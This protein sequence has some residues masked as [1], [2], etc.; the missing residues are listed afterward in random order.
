[1]DAEP[2]AGEPGGWPGLVMFDLDGT[3]VDSAPDIRLAINRVL[4]EQ[5]HEA[6]TPGDVQ[7]MIGNGIGK[8][9]ERAFAARGDIL[10]GDALA[11][12]TERMMATYR[13]NLTVETVPMP[14]ALDAVS[15]LRANGARIAVVTNK[16]ESFSREI[17]SALGF[18][19]LIDGVVG[20]DT[21]A[22][23]KPDPEMLF[24]AAASVGEVASRCVMVG[25]SPADIDAAK[26]AGV[27]SVAVRGGY[28]NV[29]AD[30][31]GADIVIERL[32]DLRRALGV[33]RTGE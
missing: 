31:L 25:D 1:M 17:L 22:T 32:S 15:D 4:G 33:L 23:R 6:L 21:C 29:P 13:A 5:G 10:A 27:A 2:C 28:T 19:E 7:S 11:A 30:R 24:H 16:P 8:L 14:G 26:A 9:V 18:A 20:G 3:L 12:R